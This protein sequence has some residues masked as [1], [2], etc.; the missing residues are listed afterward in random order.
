VI[1]LQSLLKF[2]KLS[3]AS[4]RS[5][6][7]PNP[8][9]KKMYPR[10]RLDQ[11]TD[12]V[13]SVAMTLLVIDVR[14]PEDFRPQNANELLEG[15]F[16]LKS[17]FLPYALSFGVLGMRWLSGIRLRSHVEAVAQEY[18]NWWLFYL[19]LVTCVPLTTIVVGRFAE[20]GPA[21]WLYAGNTMLLSVVAFRLLALTP[22]TEPSDLRDH[23]NSIILL[24]VSSMLAIGWSFFSASQALWVMV[25]NFAAPAITRWRWKSS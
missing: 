14:L 12:G 3:R 20:L 19:L 24:I 15:L 2:R 9:S 10:N 1:D 4:D 8:G 6:P 5:L 11:M 21:I 7:H 17:K 25:L 23:Q 22:A 16:E 13:F 18:V